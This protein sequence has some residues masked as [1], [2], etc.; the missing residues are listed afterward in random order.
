MLR[1]EFGASPGPVGAPGV[2][3]SRAMRQAG[4]ATSAK[5]FPGLGR[6][7][8]NTD[9]TA[10]VVDTITVPDD[11]LLQSF[12]AAIDAGVPFVMVALASYPRID[13]R[14]LAAF[15]PR[16]MGQ[17]LRP[18]MRFRGAIVSHH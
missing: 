17:M 14:H 18:Q 11:P 7:R 15:S 3:F 9:F 10:G 5:Q 4:V 2:A 1:R 6:V 16:V 13:T 8:G 12:Q